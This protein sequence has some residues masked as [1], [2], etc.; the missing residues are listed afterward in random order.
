M[1]ELE[2]KRKLEFGIARMRPSVM[3]HA[4]VDKEVVWLL[5]FM[6]GLLKAIA[7]EIPL[8]QPLYMIKFNILVIQLIYITWFNIFLCR[9]ATESVFKL[10]GLPIWFSHAYSGSLN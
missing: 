6:A 4:G 3:K 8:P 10:L 2:P 1:L 5:R 7:A 9:P